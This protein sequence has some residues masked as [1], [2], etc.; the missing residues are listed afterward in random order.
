V[1]FTIGGTPRTATD[2]RVHVELGGLPGVIAPVIGREP[3]DYH[4]W[5]SSG[6]DPAFIREEGPLYQGGPVWRIQQVSAQFP[7]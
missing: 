3:L 5:L 7:H 4:V 2:Y 6:P 1:A